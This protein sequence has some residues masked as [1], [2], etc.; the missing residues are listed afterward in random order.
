[1]ADL[2][3]LLKRAQ[4]LRDASQQALSEELRELEEVMD[5]HE[6]FIEDNS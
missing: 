1:M 3:N 6:R 2:D 5:E 4:A